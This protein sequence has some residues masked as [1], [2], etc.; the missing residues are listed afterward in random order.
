M[1]DET[2]AAKVTRAARGEPAADSAGQHVARDPAALRHHRR[3]R[4]ARRR[5]PGGRPGPA[6]ELSRVGGPA[7]AEGPAPTAPASALAAARESDEAGQG[8]VEYGLILF[9]MA[10]VCV[11]SL[12]FFGDQLSSLLS[13]I[14]GRLARAALERPL[15]AVSSCVTIPISRPGGPITILLVA[16]RAP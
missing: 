2:R 15:R 10:V 8:L 4:R 14:A 16:F 13:L 5:G 3:Q 11:V 12:L 6:D 7:D 9:V 1:I